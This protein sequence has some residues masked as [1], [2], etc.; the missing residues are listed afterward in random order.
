MGDGAASP[1]RKDRVLGTPILAGRGLGRQRKTI[2]NCGMVFL[3]SAILCLHPVCSGVLR[4][5][6][7]DQHRAQG[8]LISFQAGPL[9]Y[10]YAE[11][12]EGLDSRFYIAAYL[13]AVGIGFVGVFLQSYDAAVGPRVLRQ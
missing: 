4:I 10:N 12:V 1:A 9:V 11:V 8:E 7:Q 5:A 13:N 6:K 3:C 2:L